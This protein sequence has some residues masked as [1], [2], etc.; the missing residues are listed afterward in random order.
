MYINF[1]LLNRSC[2]FAQE[3]KL[4]FTLFNQNQRHKTSSV[5]SVTAKNNPI[6]LKKL[7]ITL[8][9]P[10]F[11]TNLEKS[12]Q[13]PNGKEAKLTLKLI[14]SLLNVNGGKIIGSPAERKT[15][16]S[17]IISMVQFYGCPS[18]FFTFAPDDIHSVLT[19]RMSCP[20]MHGNNAFPAVDCGFEKFL[21]EKNFT[22]HITNIMDDSINISELNLHNLLS[23]NPVAAAHIFKITLETIFEVLFG[24]TPDYLSK[25]T[26]P[27]SGRCKGI[28]GHTKAAYT[29]TEVQGVFMDI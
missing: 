28:F 1:Y 3:T 26:L 4:V 27:L 12:I 14:D 7:G 17:T 15:A 16:I 13:N 25:I 9:C 8:K 6:L 24:I 23:K 5:V 11:K 20:T 19:L 10:E 21:Q 18:I 2:A 22:P 29:V